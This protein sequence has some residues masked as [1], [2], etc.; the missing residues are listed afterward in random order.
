M[1]A[2]GPATATQIGFEMLRRVTGVNMT[3]VPFPGAPPAVNALLGEHV[4]SALSDY[5]VVAEQ[6]KAGSCQTDRF[7]NRPASD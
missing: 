2:F 5:A 7:S 3:F 1:A 4:T 6:I